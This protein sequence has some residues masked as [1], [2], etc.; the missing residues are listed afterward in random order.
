MG[1]RGWHAGHCAG[2]VKPPSPAKLAARRAFDEV[3]AQLTIS[4]ETYGA[5]KAETTTAATAAIADCEP[6]LE[7]VPEGRL[8][9]P[10]GCH[11]VPGRQRAGRCEE[12]VSEVRVRLHA[13]AIRRILLLRQDDQPPSKQPTH[14]PPPIRM[15]APPIMY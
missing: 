12:V 1:A 9:L 15:A 8:H 2:P 7:S 11:P 4:C 6:Q 13:E 10:G 14:K 5:M 3:L